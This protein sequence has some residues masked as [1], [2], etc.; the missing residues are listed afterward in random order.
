MPGILGIV[1]E[2]LEEAKLNDGVRRG[3]KKHVNKSKTP[4]SF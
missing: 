4:E 3:Q 1:Y 2:S